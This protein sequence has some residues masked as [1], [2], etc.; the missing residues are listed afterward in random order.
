MLSSGPAHASRWHLFAL[1]A[2]AILLIQ[3][4]CTNSPSPTGG[5]ERGI[6]DVSTFVDALRESGATVQVGGAVS[7]PFFSGGGQIV[8]VNGEDVQVFA[9]PDEASAAA[10]A[11]RISSDGSAIGTSM[12]SWVA[13][14]HFFRSGPVLVLYVGSSEPIQS[15]LE[16]VL[17]PQFAGR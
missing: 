1:R 7:Q 2:A 17:G 12:V 10:D 5:T 14:P 15:L 11:S 3:T 16:S 9:Y 8:R 4:G 13:P 6:V